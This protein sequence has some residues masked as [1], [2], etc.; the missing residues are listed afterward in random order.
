M[1][2]ALLVEDRHGSSH[3]EQDVNRLRGREAAALQQA[4]ERL[5]FEE[6]H[7]EEEISSPSMPG[8]NTRTTFGCSMNV[9]IWRRSTKS[10]ASP[11]RPPV[12]EQEPEPER[13]VQGTVRDLLKRLNAG[14]ARFRDRLIDA[15]RQLPPN[16]GA[17]ARFHL[18]CKNKFIAKM[19]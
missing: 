12:R 17:V 2:D 6:L 15:A 7:R 11:S 5:P 13:R 18:G 16:G 14:A 4:R 3:V 10:E 19:V 8:S 9:V 1:Q